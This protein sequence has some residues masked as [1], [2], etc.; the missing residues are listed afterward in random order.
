MGSNHKGGG[1]SLRQ[2]YAGQALIGIANS[3]WP[4][5][6]RSI[7]EGSD[8]SIVAARAAFQIADAMIAIEKDTP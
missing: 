1:M 5:D 4:S 3:I 6:L 7:A 2:Y 8:G